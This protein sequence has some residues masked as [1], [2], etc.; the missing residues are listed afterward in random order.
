VHRGF[1]VVGLE[2]HQF[3]VLII[4]FTTAFKNYRAPLLIPSMIEAG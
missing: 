1:N 3:S 2:S 4:A